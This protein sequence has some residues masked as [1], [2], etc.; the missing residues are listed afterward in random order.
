MTNLNVPSAARSSTA[1]DPLKVLAWAGDDRVLLKDCTRQG[2]HRTVIARKDEQPDAS[3]W[4][5]AVSIHDGVAHERLTSW[6]VQQ[7]DYWILWITW[8]EVMK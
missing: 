1:V 4:L 7:D 6:F 8:K 3:V 2:L 5:E